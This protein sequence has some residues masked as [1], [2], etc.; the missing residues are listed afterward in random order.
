[1]PLAT[2]AGGTV[3]LKNAHADE[4]AIFL[5]V[6]LVVNTRKIRDLK[7]VRNL[8]SRWTLYSTEWPRLGPNLIVVGKTICIMSEGQPR[9]HLNAHMLYKVFKV[10]EVLQSVDA[11]F[12]IVQN[13]TTISIKPKMKCR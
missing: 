12:L 4:S 10:F 7:F 13:S 3:L 2:S 11:S 8:Q 6:L 5:R 9:K 1:M